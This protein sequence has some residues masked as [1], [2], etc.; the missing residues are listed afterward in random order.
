MKIACGEELKQ[1]I[2]FVNNTEKDWQIKANFTQIAEKFGHYFNGPKDFL[3]KHK[4]TADYPLTF[5]PL[6]LVNQAEAKL[7]MTNPFT[8]D[9]YEY[10]LIGRAEDPLAKEHIVMNCVAR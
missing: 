3:V 1:N 10:D 4:S 9:Q 8:H 7:I 6:T 2:P 5:K